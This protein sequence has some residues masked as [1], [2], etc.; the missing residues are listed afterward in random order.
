MAA[1]RILLLTGVPGIGKT[2]IIRQV[3]ERLKDRTIRGFFTEEIREAGERQGF[4]LVA[5]DGTEQVI[6]HVNFPKIRRVGK[7]GVDVGTIDEAADRLTGDTDADLFLVDEIGKMECLSGRFIMAMHCLLSGPPPIVATIALHG[8][9]FIAE[10]KDTAGVTIWEVNHANRDT[11]SEH[12]LCWLAQ[13]GE[14]I[15]LPTPDCAGQ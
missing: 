10:A 3:A 5:F 13:G 4:R 14:K 9:G 12:V 6:A 11:L 7:Y 15:G 2:T 1:A 8:G